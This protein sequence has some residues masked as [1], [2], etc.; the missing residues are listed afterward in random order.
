MYLFTVLGF[1]ILS[2]HHRELCELS[3]E[4]SDSFHKNATQIHS[5][6]STLKYLSRNFSFTCIDHS[7]FS[8]YSSFHLCIYIC[9]STPRSVQK[10][11]IYSSFYYLYRYIPLYSSIRTKVLMDKDTFIQPSTT[12]DGNPPS[13]YIL[14]VFESFPS[15]NSS[16][17]NYIL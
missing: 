8:I 9:I 12:G 2:M 13:Y 17:F 10:S 1:T 16:Y 5:T 6:P 4:K 3:A 11:C 7:I 14:S 15:L